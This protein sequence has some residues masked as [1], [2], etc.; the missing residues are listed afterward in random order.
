M[1][2]LLN[3]VEKKRRLREKALRCMTYQTVGRMKMSKSFFRKSC[4]VS[5][6]IL[7]LLFMSGKLC[8]MK[9]IWLDD[10]TLRDQY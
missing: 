3:T 7:K 9:Y 6:K 5:P 1:G 4:D 8:L 2:K 10:L